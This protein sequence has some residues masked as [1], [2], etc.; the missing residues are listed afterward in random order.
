LHGHA[1]I[2]NGLWRDCACHQGLIIE[3]KANPGQGEP[4]LRTRAE[5]EMVLEMLITAQLRLD[6]IGLRDYS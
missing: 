3:S 4:L 5:L 2:S 6:A 1:A